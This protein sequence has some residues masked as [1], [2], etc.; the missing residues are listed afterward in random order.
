MKNFGLKL[1]RA[2]EM[3]KSWTGIWAFGLFILLATAGCEAVKEAWSE[4][5]SPQT[6]ET[7]VTDEADVKKKYV[8][9]LNAIV[10]YP[11]ATPNEQDIP[12]LDGKT[13]WINRNLLFSS[14]N[15]KDA[16]AIA[17]PG[18]PDLYDLQLKVDR[19]GRLQWQLL[20]GNH[21]S[22]PV[23]LIVD[24]I[25]FASFY[26]ESPENDTTYWITLRVGLDP[27][28]ARGITRNAKKNYESLNPG[29][30]SWF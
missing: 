23:A 20:S 6:E 24:D 22:E 9:Q 27:V 18:N 12:T 7:A 11:R 28:T 16:K 4:S 8:I 15:I 2:V 25:Y 17:R 3:K 10:K 29:S 13:I 19:F 21:G 5:V 1:K 26:P 14:K 30:S